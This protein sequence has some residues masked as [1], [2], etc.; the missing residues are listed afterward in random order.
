MSEAP[1]LLELQGIDLEIEEKEG[2]LEE[3]E[4]SLG[5]TEELLAARATLQEAEIAVRGQ[6]SEQRDLEMQIRGMDDHIKAVEGKLYG[7][8]VRSPRELGDM[9]KEAKSLRAAR[10]GL[11]DRD[12]EMMMALDESRAALQERRAASAA[13]EAAWKD[14]QAKL[15]DEKLALQDRLAVLRAQRE[16]LVPTLQPAGIKA[17]D[18]LR[19]SR[20]GRAVAEVKQNIC[21]GCRVTLPSQEATRALRSPDLVFCSSCGRILCATR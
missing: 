7:G 12:L 20:R 11:E 3:V 6:E 21:Q 14:D 4:A 16:K 19:L 8:T 13:A 18:Q 17:Y 2:R 10:S 9:E 15:E 5:E 1:R